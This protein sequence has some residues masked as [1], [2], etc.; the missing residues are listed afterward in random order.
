MTIAREKVDKNREQT[1]STGLHVASYNYA[2]GY[3]GDVMIMVKVNP[4][5]VVAVPTDYNN[6][7]MRVCQYEVMGFVNEELSN[8]YQEA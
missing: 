6:E 5:D 8:K 2:K 1:C 4:R 3:S 7:K